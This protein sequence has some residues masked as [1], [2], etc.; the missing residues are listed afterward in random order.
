MHV[1]RAS[2]NGHG[3]IQIITKLIQSS[4]LLT[5]TLQNAMMQT[6]TLML[7]SLLLK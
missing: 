4:I 7:L 6:R 5:G 1:V 2:D 3:K